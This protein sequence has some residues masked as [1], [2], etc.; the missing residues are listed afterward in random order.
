MNSDQR[1]HG[2]W[3]ASAPAGPETTN[4]AGALNADVVIIGA[5]YTGCSAALH[6][7]LSGARPVVLEAEEIGFGGA[8]RNVGLVNAG[9]W[10]M[11]DIVLEAAGQDRGERIVQQLSEAPGLVFDLI[12]RHHI[13]CEA[14]RSGTLH[15]AADRKGVANLEQRTRQWHRRGVAVKLLEGREAARLTGSEAFPAVLLDHRAGTVQ[16]LAYVRGLAEAAIRHGAKIHTRS[17]ALACED[18]GDRWQ[19][20]TSGGSI[21]AQMVIVATDAYSAGPWRELGRE[22]VPLPYFN[23]ATAPLPTDIRATILPDGQGAWDT[24]SI[25]SSFRLDDAGRLVFGSVGAL[26]SGGMRVHARWA[27]RE[28]ARL[29][30][31]LRSIEFDYAWYGMIGMTKD[32]LPRLHALDRNIFSISGYNGRGIAPGTSFG[33]DLARLVLGEVRLDELSLAQAP[34]KPVPFRTLKGTFYEAGAQVAHAVGARFGFLNT[35]PLTSQRTRK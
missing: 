22:Q 35:E 16:P 2:L 7:A 5:G 21:T 13:A 26:R 6:L 18:L 30:P 11:P 25:L 31:T 23:L 9:L 4:L 17:P 20:T 1:S 28:L 10:V 15:C 33:R 3:E 14:V 32:A 12:A 19:I 8:G 34:V 24:K 27:R 29:F